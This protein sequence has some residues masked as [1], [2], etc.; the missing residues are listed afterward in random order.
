MTWCKGSVVQALA[1]G[2]LHRRAG[3]TMERIRNKDA[4][5]SPIWFASRKTSMMTNSRHHCSISFANHNSKQQAVQQ[6]WHLHGPPKTIPGCWDHIVKH[7]SISKQ[8]HIDSQTHASC[9]HIHP[10]CNQTW[11]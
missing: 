6:D 2:S 11:S 1:S 8:K 9:D 4:S 5:Q 7:T 10:C 3:N